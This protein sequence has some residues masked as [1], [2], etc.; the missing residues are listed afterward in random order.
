[1][2]SIVLASASPRR[3][4]LFRLMNIPFTV[5]PAEIEEEID[6]S[7]EPAEIACSLARQKGITVS[8]KYPQAVVIAADTIV[9]HNGYVLC[10]PQNEEDAADMLRN[11][12][13]TDHFVFSGVFIKGGGGINGPTESFT[14]FGRTKVSFSTLDEMEIEQYISTGSPMDKAGAYGI[15]DDIG[16]LFVEKIEGDFYNVVGFPVNKFYQLLKNDYP[17][18]FKLIF[19]R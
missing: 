1:M 8:D 6:E 7:L 18:L 3:H 4:H 10:K 9:V 11:L 5:H 13:G 17:S 16:S 19:K 15:Q 2:A 14:F 12:S